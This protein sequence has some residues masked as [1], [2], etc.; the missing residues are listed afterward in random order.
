MAIPSRPRQSARRATMAAALCSGKQFK[1]ARRHGQNQVDELKI[2]AQAMT[3]LAMD[4]L[5]Q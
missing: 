5:G 2:M 3:A 4:S 1:H